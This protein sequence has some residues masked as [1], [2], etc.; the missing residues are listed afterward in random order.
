MAHQYRVEQ[1]DTL[2]SI[3]QDYGF[4]DWRRIWDHPDNVVLRAKRGS[5]ELLCPG[6]VVVVPMHETKWVSCNTNAVHEF[7]ISRPRRDVTLSLLRGDGSPYAGCRYT[8]RAGGSEAQGVVPSSGTIRHRLDTHETAGTLQLWFEDSANP[9]EFEL[10]LGHLEPVAESV[11][12]LARLRNLGYYLG[13]PE[14]SLDDE[15]VKLAL[16]TFARDHELVAADLGV[17]QRE[18]ERAYGC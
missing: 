1:G 10:Q 13:D 16:E 5:P 2:A 9:A 11:G 4:R 12:T 14:A 18:L 6:D 15:P 7:V 8:L 3:A 17:V